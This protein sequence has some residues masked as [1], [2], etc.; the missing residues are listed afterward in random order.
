M[1]SAQFICS[2]KNFQDILKCINE[3]GVDLSRAASMARNEGL[4]TIAPFS[5]IPGLAGELVT[6]ALFTV[7]PR[8]MTSPEVHVCRVA[9]PHIDD[10]AYDY[11]VGLVL[12]GNHVLYTGTGRAV[13]DLRPGAVYMLNNKKLHGAKQHDDS[14]LVFVTI[15]FQAESMK[16]AMR[17][18][19]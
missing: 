5:D 12:M 11:T 7:R 2:L 14:P 10:V 4:G 17:Y 13:C 9:F 1:R 15:D 16:D 18:V 6:E 19:T 8:C 3:C